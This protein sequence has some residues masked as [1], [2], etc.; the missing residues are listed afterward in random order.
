MVME[1]AFISVDGN[2]LIN[3]TDRA[4]VRSQCMHGVN[5]RQDSRRSRQSV[6]RQQKA[7]DNKTVPDSHK[8]L[9]REDTPS[10]MNV[11]LSSA[12]YDMILS[13]TASSLSLA[14]CDSFQSKEILFTC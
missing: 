7:V 14:C 1:F 4:T 2:G 11:K 13:S 5:K 3:A 8:A 9:K 6:R 10:G 12:V